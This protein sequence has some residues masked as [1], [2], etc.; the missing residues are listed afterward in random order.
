MLA[1]KHSN[2]LIVTLV[3]LLL[4]LP[5][6]TKA[7][8]AINIPYMEDAK[9]FAEFTDEL[10]AVINYY[11]QYSEQEIIS[12]YQSVYGEVSHTE[13]K[14]GSLTFSFEHDKNQLRVIISSQGSKRQVD[15][16]LQ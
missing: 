10:P 1:T 8:E 9:I 6:T 12:F 5:L 15:A 16:I 11:T 4:A 13:I 14:R 3:S 7:Q 2:E